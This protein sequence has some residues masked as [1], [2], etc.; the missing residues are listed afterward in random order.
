MKRLARWLG[1]L[2][3]MALLGLAGL[4]GAGHL[5]SR[6]VA[7]TVY[8]VNDPPLSLPTDSHAIAHGAHLFETRGCADCH[9]ADARGKEVFDAGPVIRVVASNISPGALKAKGYDSPDRIAAAIRHGVR[10]DGT[11]LLFMPAADWHNLGDSDTAALI[12]YLLTLPDQSHD[13]GRSELRP[14]GRVLAMLGRFPAYPAS[15]L[16]HSPR[17]RA[18]PEATVS[19]EFG[20]YVAESCTGCHGVDFAGGKV[21][22][23]NTPPTANLTPRAL[24]DWN[25]ADFLR[26]MR[27]GKRKDGSAI[28]P[29]MPW[30]IYAKMTDVELKALWAYLQQLP[31]AG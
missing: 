11:P 23:P 17:A 16:D 9:G 1:V 6:S 30:S 14:L 27:E 31:A 12:A 7:G 19:V 29:F 13:P 24:G 5:H 18:V 28:D 4:F 20:R 10:A 8:A 21:L 25:E 26:A 15:L 3:L 2:L 22:A